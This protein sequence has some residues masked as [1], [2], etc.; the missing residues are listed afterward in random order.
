VEIEASATPVEGLT[1][2]G[3]YAYVDSYYRDFRGCTAGGA[4]C[5][6][7]Q[8]PFTPKNSLTVYAQ[9]NFDVPELNGNLTFRV[10]D[11]WADKYQF[12]SPLND[13]RS[14][15]LSGKKNFANVFLTYENQS[16]NW[17]LQAW[18]RNV[19]SKTAVTFG[20]NYFFYLLTN[21]EYNSGLRVADRTSV[22]EPRSFGLT[23]RYKF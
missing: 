18:S 6:G 19:F 21:D 4:D 5:S 20:T 9:Y 13:V 12:L 7:N 3:N 8:R 17:S 23:A 14:A 10:E 11:H 22:T 16:G 1:L 15:E 2:G